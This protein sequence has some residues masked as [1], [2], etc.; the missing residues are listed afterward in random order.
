MLLDDATVPRIQKMYVHPSRAAKPDAESKTARRKVGRHKTEASECWHW[1]SI[2][3]H[4]WMHELHRS[5]SSF[6]D[7][8]AIP[9][10][11]H[12]LPEPAAAPE[13]VPNENV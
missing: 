4:D 8:W 3:K 12:K 7:E 11:D 10:P 1:C 13:T 9:C 6:L 2:G 5:S